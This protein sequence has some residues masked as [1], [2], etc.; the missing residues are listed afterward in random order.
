M[1]IFLIHNENVVVFTTFWIFKSLLFSCVTLLYSL[2][3]KVYNLIKNKYIPLDYLVNDR[4][5]RLAVL[6][7]IID[8]DGNVRANGHEIDSALW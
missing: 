6:A 7:G 5:T 1:W 4:K 2:L 8:T 3:L